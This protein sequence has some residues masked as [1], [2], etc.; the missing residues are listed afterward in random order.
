MIVSCLTPMTRLVAK[1]H[2][3]IAQD[4][5]IYIGVKQMSQYVMGTYCL[6]VDH[7]Y[8]YEDYNNEKQTIVFDQN[9]LVKKPGYE[10]LISHIDKAEFK[11]V[12]QWIY[13][14]ITRGKK[15]YRFLVGFKR[16]G[17]INE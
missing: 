11:V 2:Q 15:D 12:N 1:S 5:D 13:V 6:S 7:G 8:E 17:K 10:I 3:F 16:E 9:R 14:D 4:E